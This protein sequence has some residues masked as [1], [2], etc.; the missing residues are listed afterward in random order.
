MICAP[1]TYTSEKKY[2][3]LNGPSRQ[4]LSKGYLG[5]NQSPEERVRQIALAAEK[6]LWPGFA[7]KFE[8]Y[9]SKSWFS[10]ASPVWS[11]FGT[12]KGLPISCNGTYVPDSI[13]GIMS[14]VTEIAIQSKNSAGTSGYLGHIRP[15]GSKITTGGTTLGP[16]SFIEIF[17]KTISVVAQSSMRRGIF[18]AYLDVEHS[19][20]EE[21]LEIRKEGHPI[22]EIQFGVCIGDEWMNSM[23]GGDRKKR[24]V[25]C[26]IIQ[27]RYES[28][29]PYIF[30]TDNA[31]NQAPQVYKDKNKRIH[32]SNACSEIFLS[33]DELESFVCCLSS[34]NLLHYEEW[35][36]TDAVETLLYFLDA[37]MSEYIEKTADIKEMKRAHDF[38]KNQRAVGLGV[39]GWASYLRK[40]LIPFE[41]MAAKLK[42]VEIFQL[43]Q[44]KTNSAT[45][46]L[47]EVLG[48]PPL[49]EQYGRRNATTMALAPTTSSSFI[50]GQV[51]PSIEP[52]AA[53]MFT[54]MLAKGNYTHKCPHLKK[55]LTKYGLN[56]KETWK[57]ILVSGGSVQ[58]LDFPT[59]EVF[60]TF[61]EIS[62]REIVIQAA[63]RQPYIDQGQSLNLM[64][65]PNTSPEEVSELMIEGWEMG[66]KSFYYQRSCNPAQEL[67]RSIMSCSS[68]EA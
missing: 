17:D 34:M 10:L 39:L 59:K 20:I 62:Q 36:D 37:V 24:D 58:H 27:K 40:N 61:A 32:A 41:S 19:D 5:E 33:S 16:M 48:E 44:K 7:D 23:L 42:N 38:A 30:F 51:S 15:R 22:Q 57:S 52:L 6:R 35:K 1:Q 21:F 68:C 47:A 18:S 49:L 25:W 26:K 56:N 45:E 29:F 11:N 55:E 4:F 53:N 31:N 46:H 54:K 66:I 28:G 14:A 3:W 65:P 63:Q 13:S 9:V 67:A 50:L 43:L 2:T 64:I 8:D 60:K 12:N